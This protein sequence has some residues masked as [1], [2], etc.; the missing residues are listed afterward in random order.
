MTAVAR[1]GFSANAPKQRLRTATGGRGFAAIA[2]APFLAFLAVFALYPLGELVRLAFSETQVEEG[3][4]ISSPSGIANFEEVWADP[5]TQQS[6][7]VT[8][9]FI[10]LTVVGTV[11][12]GT[13]LALLVDRAGWSR[14]LARNVFVWPA[15]VAPVVVSLMWLLVLSPTVGGLNKFLINMGLPSQ[16]WLNSETGAFLSVSLV[17]I[18]HWTPIVFLFVYAALQGVPR[19]ILEAARVDGANEWQVT[20]RV[21]L[22]MLTPAILVV[23]LVRL[24]SSIK[25]FDEMYLLTRGGPNGATNI[26]SLHIRTLFFDQLEFGP[27]AA[28]SV[29]VVAAVLAIVGG[30]LFARRFASRSKIPR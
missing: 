12:L 9:L 19:E 15:V 8:L 13:T 23:T 16:S 22:P 27:A 24:V 14:T 21:I 4:F 10:C 29:S 17:D 5:T 20:M 1:A 18:W 2:L 26:V 25:A 7:L 6:I 30:A 28:L 3:Q 11:S